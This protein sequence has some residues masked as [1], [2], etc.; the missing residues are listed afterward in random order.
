MK[1]TIDNFKEYGSLLRNLNP[2]TL[3]S[4]IDKLNQQTKKKESIIKDKLKIK[5]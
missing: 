1:K 4:I 3:K 5:R 2:A